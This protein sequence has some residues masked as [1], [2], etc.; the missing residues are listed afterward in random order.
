MQS[1]NRR[2]KADTS[3]SDRT[4]KINGGADL[5]PESSSQPVG[6]NRPPQQ[7][8]VR[9]ERPFNHYDLTRRA[10]ERDHVYDTGLDHYDYHETYEE[11][12]DIATDSPDTTKGPNQ[13]RREI[14]TASSTNH[15]TPYY[16][17]PGRFS[18][19][20]KLGQF[21]SNHRAREI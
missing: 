2:R 16:H 17:N 15:M 5:S 13:I 3:K 14:G 4:G 10:Q 20:E 21:A 12:Y 18:M 6:L 7:S 19:V 9:S 8:M 1:L 11:V